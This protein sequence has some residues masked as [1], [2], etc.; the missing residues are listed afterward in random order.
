MKED[1]FILSEK[2]EHYDTIPDELEVKDVKEFIKR[3]KE[4]IS[5]LEKG[6]KE[7]ETGLMIWDYD[8]YKLIDKL[9]GDKLK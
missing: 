6:R 4:D 9:S 5:K 7:D 1:N 2:I 8:V 3:L